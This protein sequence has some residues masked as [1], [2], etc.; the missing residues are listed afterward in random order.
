[1]VEIAKALSANARIII[2]DEPTAAL[3]KQESDQLHRICDQLRDEGKSIIFISHRFEDMWRLA[4]RVTVLRDAR[5]IGTWD[6]DTVSGDAL[7][8]AMVGREIS[9]MFPKRNAKIGKELL[10][11][12]NLG[13]TGVFAD[14]NLSVHA[15]EIV[16]LTGLVG[17]GRTEV[18]QAIF[19]L[20]PW[21]SG[22]LFVNGVETNVLGPRNAMRQGIAYLPEDRQKQ[23]LVLSWPIGRN[24]TLSVIDSIS[25]HGLLNPA[26]EA[27][28]AQAQ[29][30]RL[31]V[32]ATGIGALAGS[33]S[34]GNQQKVIVAK[35][36]ASDLKCIMLDE[37]TKG[38]DVGAK[39]AMYEIMSE[40]TESGYGILLV[41][42]EMPEVIAMSDR[43]LVMKEG[44]IMGELTKENV[45]QEKI[46]SLAMTSAPQEGE[47]KA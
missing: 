8:M 5:Y 37:P 36:L 32:R 45:S 11:T 31:G 4:D 16:S 6:A 10:R 40:L 19:G 25:P 29:F 17:A 43:V 22:K 41:S 30:D 33:L 21:T 14:I 27:S 12:E 42:S 18:C 28:V 20:E 35:L 13:C 23:G 7:I 38:V 2:M 9:N 24:I 26:A 46:L 34:G 1:M 39:Q 44:R 47:L 15:G 3:T